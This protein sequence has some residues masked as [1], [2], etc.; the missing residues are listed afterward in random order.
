MRKSIRDL[1]LAEAHAAKAV[2][3]LAEKEERDLTEAELGEI[4]AHMKKAAELKANAEKEEQFR[5]QMTDLSQGL[6]LGETGDDVKKRRG[7]KDVP[8]GMTLGTRFTQSPEY[9]ALLAST[10][11]GQFSAKMRV[12]SSPMDVPGGMKALFFSTDHD[13]NSGALVRPDYLGLLDPYYERPLTIRSLFTAGST[14]SDTIEYVRVDT[15]T[16]NAAPVPEAISNAAI[17]DGTGG[18][19]TPVDGGVKP[20]STFDFE[21]D[22]TTVKTIAHWTAATKRTLADA[23][24]LRTLIDSFLRYG[25]E[26]EFEDQLVAGNGTGENFL[27]LANTPG[28]QTQTPG[29]GEDAFVVTRKA[30][31]K[32]Q[33]GG[34][35]TPTA[36]VMNPL[37]WEAV[38]LM[39]NAVN[40]DFFSNGPFAMMTPHLWGLPVVLSEAIPAKTAYCAAWNYG[41]IWDREQ[42]T[43]QAT[44]SHADYF[45]RNLVAI[46]SEMRA[47]FAILRPPAFV[48]IT[49]P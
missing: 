9:K 1:I 18:T 17:G 39:R 37:D 40:G 23:G 44:D 46:L 6:G 5:A 45:V 32:V 24:Q 49:L 10:P 30:R 47:A 27:G 28:I 4:D 19:A 41:V 36:Y 2:V 26:E 38:E 33:I 16:N 15:V 25:L 3:E 35:A 22:S 21:K 48:K 29:A 34:R 11:N 42:A 13:T 31:T 12:H 7:E 43:V 20:Q 8:G 14:Q